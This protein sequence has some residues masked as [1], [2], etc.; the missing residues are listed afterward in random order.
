MLLEVPN[1]EVIV[2]SAMEEVSIDFVYLPYQLFH[3]ISFSLNFII[4]YKQK[5]YKSSKNNFDT[6]Y[7]LTLKLYVNLLKQ[8][9]IS[10]IF[11]NLIYIIFT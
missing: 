10:T 3:Y 4:F 6:F 9:M 5:Y 1:K 7:H 8:I 11:N 2:H